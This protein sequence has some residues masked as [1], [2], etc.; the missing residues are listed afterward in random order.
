MTAPGRNVRGYVKR[1]VRAVLLAEKLQ[2]RLDALEPLRPK[3]RLAKDAADAARLKLR[4]GQ[5]EEAR[6]LVDAALTAH[7]ATTRAET[8]RPSGG[9]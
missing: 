2:A 3:H 1:Q 8:V 4:G 5:D 9:M 6:R 7:R